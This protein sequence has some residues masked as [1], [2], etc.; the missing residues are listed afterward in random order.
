MCLSLC[1]RG[2][3]SFGGSVLFGRLVIMVRLPGSQQ[4][5]ERFY[6]AC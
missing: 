3:F 2:G 4:S 6:A 1:I 5:T